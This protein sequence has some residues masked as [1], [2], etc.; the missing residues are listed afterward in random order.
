M[1]A[2]SVLE[3]EEM[4]VC[5]AVMNV[6]LRYLLCREHC[7]RSSGGQ[8]AVSAPGYLSIVQTTEL[9]QWTG[10]WT[11]LLRDKRKQSIGRA[12]D[13]GRWFSV[14]QWSDASWRACAVT[15]FCLSKN[16]DVENSLATSKCGDLAL[17]V[18]GVSDETVK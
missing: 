12:A 8:G 5:H 17:Q 1:R 4:S 16:S 11:T 10:H 9:K 14:A 15:L 3:N 7:R 6:T 2:A 18:G 13:F